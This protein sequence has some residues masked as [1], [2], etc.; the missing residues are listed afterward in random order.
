MKCM[1]E[2]VQNCQ[3]IIRENFNKPLEMTKED[4]EAFRNATHCHICDKKYTDTYSLCYHIQ[5]DDAYRDFYISKDLFDNNDYNNSSRFFFDENK[6]VIGKFKDE[7][8]G[9]PIINICW[10]KKQNVFL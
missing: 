8:A 4:E 6:K 2:V 9:N 3:K 5:T 1:F 7:A 10:F